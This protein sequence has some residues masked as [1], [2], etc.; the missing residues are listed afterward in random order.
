MSLKSFLLT[1]LSGVLVAATA[2]GGTLAYLMSTD[3][4]VNVMTL[5]NVKIEQVEYE[6]DVNGDLTEFTQTKPALP[7]VYDTEAWAMEA[8]PIPASLVNTPLAQPTRRAWIQEPI[9]PP[10]TASGEK[11][12]ERI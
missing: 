4:D 6:R 10:V 3:S 5:G 12:P 8:V 1:G 7:A 2:V 11:A 9:T